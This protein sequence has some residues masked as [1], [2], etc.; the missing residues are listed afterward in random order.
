[1]T[2]ITLSPYQCKRA[3]Q[4]TLA[5]GQDEKCKFLVADALKQPFRANFFDLGEPPLPVLLFRIYFAD[6]CFTVWSMES[7]EHMPNKQ[8]FVNEI[9][10]VCAPD[11]RII[12]VTWC[13]RDLE[14]GEASLNPKEERLL[15]RINTAYYL[16]RWCSVADYRKYFENA[17]VPFKFLLRPETPTPLSF[18]LSP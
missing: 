4:V 7:G 8:E 11:G 12:V 9:A 15:N 10:R 5:A 1:M 18:D 3:E 14:A 6:P 2:G 16:P 17:G 13:H